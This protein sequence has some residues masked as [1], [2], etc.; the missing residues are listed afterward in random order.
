MW[1]S[2]LSWRRRVGA[3]R[4]PRRL[5]RGGSDRQ[6]LLGR[7]D[8]GRA[9]RGNGGGVAP[10]AGG[11]GR[12]SRLDH[13]PPHWRGQRRGR[14]RLRRARQA[15]AGSPRLPSRVQGNRAR[16]ISHRQRLRHFALHAVLPDAP[17]VRRQGARALPVPA[18]GL[19]SERTDAARRLQLPLHLLLARRPACVARPDGQVLRFRRG[20]RRG[21]ALRRGGEGQDVPT[22]FVKLLPLDTAGNSFLGVAT[23]NK[24]WQITREMH[25][26]GSATASTISV[27]SIWV[28]HSL[29]TIL[30]EV[31]ADPASETIYLRTRRSIG[32]LTRNQDGAWNV[33]TPIVQ[34][35]DQP[36]LVGLAPMPKGRLALLSR[37]APLRPPPRQRHLGRCAGPPWSVCATS[38]PCRRATTASS[39]T[40]RKPR[41]LRARRWQAIA[42]VHRPLAGAGRQLATGEVVSVANG[43]QIFAAPPRPEDDQVALTLAQMREDERVGGQGGRFQPG[44]RHPSSARRCELR[45]RV[46]RFAGFRLRAG[47]D[48]RHPLDRPRPCR[49]PARRRHHRLLVG[50]PAAARSSRRSPRPMPAA[51]RATTASSGF[52]AWPTTTSSPSVRWSTRSSAPCPA[53]RP[54]SS[55]SIRASA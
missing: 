42:G 38:I 15:I 16:R 55:P 53:R 44:L 34:P 17:P 1:P 4:F 20:R 32:M 47:A 35:Q 2:G 50:L 46:G 41:L 13:R 22:D 39:S 48:D 21:H 51:P 11:A 5:R 45:R 54:L 19:Q 6:R 31:Y 9:C 30:Q 8:R 29:E 10:P 24:L 33:R 14:Q 18:V 52:C 28:P 27:K 23:G 37:T 7:A 3:R 49:G 25:S 40:C 26:N 36:A 12:H 43:L